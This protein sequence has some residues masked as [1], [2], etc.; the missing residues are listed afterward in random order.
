MYLKVAKFQDLLNILEKALVVKPGN[1]DNG[2]PN[3]DNSAPNAYSK[4]G[5]G[6]TTNN[7]T[8]QS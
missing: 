3:R 6:D 5:L 4:T 7:K 8:Y 2:A 1:E